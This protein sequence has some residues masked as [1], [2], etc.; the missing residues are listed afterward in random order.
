MLH[1]ALHKE[2]VISLVGRA[3][4]QA[5]FPDLQFA[6]PEAEEVLGKVEVEVDGL[7]EAHLRAATVETM[8]VD[9]LVRG[10][11]RRHREG[12]A[13][14]LHPALCTRFS[15]VD[16]GRL[17][18]V[19][20][21]RPGVAE[22]KHRLYSTP[23]RHMVATCRSLACGCWMTALSLADGLPVLVISQGPLRR[24]SAEE[25]DAFLT[26]AS[27]HL[28]AGTE[29]VL[30][31]GA[32]RP[33]RPSDSGGR[34]GCLE[35]SAPNGGIARYPRLRFAGAQQALEIAHLRVL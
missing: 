28:P 5:R 4:A 23:A 3:Q 25:L 20:L 1:L 22:V 7:D 15:R 32:R 27:E 34:R 10:F 2:E 31:H 19:D 24:C 14:A 9:A 12:L 17:R 13:V 21:D 29:L 33:F 16:N 8:A 18:W 6:D 26:R 30:D 35:V 11:F